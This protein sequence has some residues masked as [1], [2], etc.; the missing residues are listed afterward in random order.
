MAQEH[1]TPNKGPTPESLGG[2]TREQQGE[3]RAMLDRLARLW[4]ELMTAASNRDQCRV[5]DIQAEIAACRG[6]V[7]EIRRTGTSGSA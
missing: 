4:S 2:I 6:R 7:E 5:E 3:L 1:M